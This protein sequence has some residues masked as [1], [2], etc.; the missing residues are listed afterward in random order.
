LLDA[1]RIL[2]ARGYNPGTVLEM[3]HV[4]AAEAALTGPIS[5]AAGLD[6]KDAK[7]VS[8]RP[9]AEGRAKADAS[10]ID[11]AERSGGTNP[12]PGAPN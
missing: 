7:F 1:A 3:R 5:V 8:H 4:G 9:C 11:H 12:A 6:V 10:L 2:I